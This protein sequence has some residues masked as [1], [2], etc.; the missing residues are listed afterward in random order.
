MKSCA[1]DLKGNEN[2]SDSDENVSDTNWN[3][4]HSISS[5]VKV[6][7]SIGSLVTS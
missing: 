4:D 7:A 1:V 3:K 5:F 2:L 6:T